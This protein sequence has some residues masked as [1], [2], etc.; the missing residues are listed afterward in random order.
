MALV[1]IADADDMALWTK[2]SGLLGRD[3]LNSTRAYVA[4]ALFGRRMA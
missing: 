4:G 2:I 3:E 1:Q